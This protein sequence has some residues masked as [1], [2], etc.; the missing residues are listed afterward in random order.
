MKKI[1]LFLLLVLIPS[2]FCYWF[3]EST[4]DY[5]DGKYNAAIT[6]LNEAFKFKNASGK[7]DGI[8]F[9]DNGYFVTT[10]GKSSEEIYSIEIHEACHD[11]VYKQRVHFC[12]E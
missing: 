7:I 4:K 5:Y 6:T 1:L 2:V 9:T 8:Y 12:H 10:K 3:T 11:L